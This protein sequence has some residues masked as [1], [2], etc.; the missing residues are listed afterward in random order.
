MVRGVHL[1]DIEK[2][3]ER[4]DLAELFTNEVREL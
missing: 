1:A 2:A 3:L 4:S